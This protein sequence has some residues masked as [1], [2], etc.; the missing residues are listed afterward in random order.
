MGIVLCRLHY[1]WMGGLA[2]SISSFP[3]NHQQV[4]LAISNLRFKAKP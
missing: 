1:M 3:G 2:G 4:G